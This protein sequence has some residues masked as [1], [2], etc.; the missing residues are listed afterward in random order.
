MI[1]RSAGPPV[2][3]LTIFG[4]IAAAAGILIQVVSGVDEY[5]AIPP[6]L[7]LLLLVAALV[8][9]GSRWWWT[10]LLGALVAAFILFGAY[11]TA[12]TAERLA[13]P[14]RLGAFA[15][16]VVQLLGLATAAI[17]G[18]VATVRNGRSR[19]PRR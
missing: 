12:G 19:P 10:P 5:P 16:T 4:L 1:G 11:A 6:G 8:A 17:A 18:T 7:L 14:E 9:V 3:T 2:G 13:Q 15:G